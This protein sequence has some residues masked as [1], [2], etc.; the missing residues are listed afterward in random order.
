MFVKRDTL[1]FMLSVWRPSSPE[2]STPVIRKH[3]VLWA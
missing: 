3:S 2:E 1:Y